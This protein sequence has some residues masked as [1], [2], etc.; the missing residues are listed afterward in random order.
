MSDEH[1]PEADRV[2]GAPHPRETRE[3]F[4]QD[5]AQAAFLQA[6]ESGRLH[7]AWLLT[8]P[9]G[10]GKATLAWRIARHLAAREDAD[11]GGGLFGDAPPPP[12]LE[13]PEDHPVWRRS[14]ALAEPRISLCRRAWDPKAKRLMTRISVDEIRRLK[15]A[16]ALSAADGGWRAAII[17]SADEMNREAQNALLK[18]LE[19]PPKNTVLLLVCHQPARLLPTIRSRCR[20]LRLLPLSAEDLARA[21]HQAEQP[22]EEVEILHRLSNGA[23]GDAVRLLAGDGPALY[24]SILEIVGQAPRMDIGAIGALA[25]RC[26]GATNAPRYD[27]VI[28]LLPLLLARLARAGCGQDADLLPE[29][30]TLAARLSPDIVTARGWAETQQQITERADYARSVNLD[31]EQVILDMFLAI[32]RR[33]AQGAAT[34]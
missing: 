1:L 21:L 5:A 10:I 30:A 24:R 12:S 20:E 25:A 32:Q 22:I 26:V 29:E 17:D 15:S 2:E 3:L 23:P 19:E 8:G 4:G 27:A 28:R 7:H 31:P 9:R 34:V 16:F 33:A 6:A 18:L 13:M 14:L 11:A